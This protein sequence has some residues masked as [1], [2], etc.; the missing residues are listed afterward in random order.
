VPHATL[1]RA[2]LA[3]SPELTKRCHNLGNG[4]V[5]VAVAVAVVLAVARLGLVCVLETLETLETLLEMLEPSPSPSPSP[6]GTSVE[7]GK[8]SRLYKN[9]GNL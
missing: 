8:H 6:G 3:P 7:C 9:A 2:I 4:A 5:A 1:P